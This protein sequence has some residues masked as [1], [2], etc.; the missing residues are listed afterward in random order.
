MNCC[1]AWGCADTEPAAPSASRRAREKERTGLGKLFM[2]GSRRVAVR[3]DVGRGRSFTPGLPRALRDDL[4]PRQA[5]ELREDDVVVEGRLEAGGARREIG[6]HGV[7][8]RLRFDRPD[9]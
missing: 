8:E 6:L 2:E 7:D 3:F 1:A 9:L 4:S 5:F